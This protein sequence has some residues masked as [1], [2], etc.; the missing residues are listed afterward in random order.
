MDFLISNLKRAAIR[1]PVQPPVPG[2]GIATNAKSPH[3][4]YFTMLLLFTL[5]FF[6]KK[7]AILWNFVFFKKANILSINKIITGSGKI[8]PK[9]QI[10]NAIYHSRFKR[11][12]AISPPLNSRIGTSEIK[13]TTSSLGILD[14]A[15]TID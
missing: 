9:R 14:S 7:S 2:K 6:S 10:G 8:L 11:L 4:L 5:A 12:A 15:T 13:K 3:S 1:A